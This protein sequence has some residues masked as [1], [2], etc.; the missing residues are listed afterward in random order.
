MLQVQAQWWLISKF[1]KVAQKWT[2]PAHST[3]TVFWF[4]NEVKPTI[5][6]FRLNQISYGS[7]LSGFSGKNDENPSN[8]QKLLDWFWLKKICALPGAPKTMCE[9]FKSIPLV[10]FEFYGNRVTD[11]LTPLAYYNIDLHTW[12]NCKCACSCVKPYDLVHWPL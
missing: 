1:V 12:R 2:T 4:R 3:W 10:V 8:T 6:H 7:K 9:N 11:S 5:G